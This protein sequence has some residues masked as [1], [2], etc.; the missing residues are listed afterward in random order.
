M[1]GEKIKTVS[2]N[3]FQRMSER[4]KCSSVLFSSL[5]DAFLAAVFLVFLFATRLTPVRFLTAFF[6]CLFAGG[7]FDVVL[8]TIFLVKCKCCKKRNYS[9]IHM[10]KIKDSWGARGAKMGLLNCGK[11][12]F[13]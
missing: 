11:S 7:T 1:N 9:G 6:F 12:I 8:F 13:M 3:F 5:R 4:R 10:P 2:A